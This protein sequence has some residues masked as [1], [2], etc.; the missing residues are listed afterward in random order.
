MLT[1]ELRSIDAWRA[2][3]PHLHIC[4]EAFI[5]A[6]AP[7]D[8]TPQQKTGAAAAIKLEGYIQGNVGEWGIDTTAMANTVR[9]LSEQNLSPVFA[10]LY[11]EYWIPFHRLHHMFASLLGGKYFALPDCWIWNVD[12]RKG[13][14]GWP[15]HRDQ[16]FKSLYPNRMPKSLTTWIPLSPANPVNGCM[17]L[18][19]ANLDPTYGTERDN[20]W[21]FDLPSVRALPG[22]P[23]DY[24]V[25]SQ[26]VLHWGGKTSPLA[27][28]SRVS[29]AFEFQ[30]ADM[31]PLNQPLIEP[32]TILNFDQRLKLI[33]KQILQY[34][35]M[36]KVAP[37][38]EQVATELLA[39]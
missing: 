16:G 35:H 25:W 15:P 26:A 1:A 13:D 18:V 7:I 17:Y 39:Q 20:E 12:P 30:R 4:D 31:P 24:F 2:R 32:R 14:A 3:A 8:I 10:Y 6:H 37:E 5:R 36:Y 27:T 34:R 38:V 23:G 9:V 11:D 33:A 21:K 19:P 29:M 22:K 28:E